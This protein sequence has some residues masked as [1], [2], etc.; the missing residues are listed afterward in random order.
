MVAKNAAVSVEASA[1][2]EI[3]YPES[4]GMPLPDGFYQLDHFTGI[5]LALKLFFDS[6]ITNERD[7]RGRSERTIR[8]Y[9]MR[10]AI[11]A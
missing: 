10:K 2:T 7:S 3:F 5:L 8:S 9:T 6:F 11:P 1:R 4:D